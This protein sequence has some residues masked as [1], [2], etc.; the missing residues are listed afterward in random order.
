MCK[1]LGALLDKTLTFRDHAKHRSKVAIGNIYKLMHIRRFMD[2]QTCEILVY[3]LVISHLDYANGILTGASESVI[4]DL[5]RVQNWAA[6]LIL[7]R[8][9]KDSSTSARYDLHWLPIRHRIDFKICMLIKKCLRGEAPKY[10]Q[11]LLCIN[12]QK[13]NLRNFSNKLIVPFVHKNSFAVR[14]FSVHGPRLWNSLPNDIGN[15]LNLD[16]FK[17]K[18]KTYL[19]RDAYHLNS[20]FLYY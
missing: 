5:Q 16:V 19:F 10:L 15:E 13:H 6:K 12:Y 8:K 9:K 18:L 11:D 20:D 7:K 4:R 17:T 2:R 14:A 1:Y 3:S